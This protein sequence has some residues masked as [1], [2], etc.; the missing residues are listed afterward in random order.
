VRPSIRSSVGLLLVATWSVATPA[1]AARDR[2]VEAR[3][4]LDVHQE[5]DFNSGTTRRGFTLIESGSGER[6]TLRFSPEGEPQLRTGS[7]IVVRGLLVGRELRVGGDPRRPDV[8][9]VAAAEAPAATPRRAV[10]LVVDFSDSA[11]SCSDASIASL[12]FT[13]A[14]SVDGLYQATTNGQVSL[15]GD[16]D[17]NGQPD[18]FRVSIPRSVS[19][20][21]DAYGWAAEAEAAAPAAGVDL[22][23]YQHRIFVL[24]SSTSC[25]WAGLGNVGCGAWCRAWIKTCNVTDIYAHEIGHNLDLAH[26]S[27]DTNNDGAIDCEY[28]DT[29]DFMGYG[30]VGYR[31]T[32][33]PHRHQKAWLPPDKIVEVSTAGTSTWVLS[34]LQ[35]DP[36]TAPYPQVLKIHKADTGDWYYLSYRQRAGYD[37]TLDAAYVDRTSVHRYAGAGYH[38]TL[39]LAALADTSTFSDVPNGVTVRQV[40]H[41]SM[42]ATLQ[43]ATT[44]IAVAPTVT[45]SPARQ[46]AQPGV[47]LAYT[48]TVTNHDPAVC[49]P[50]AFDLSAS[51]PTG[52][53][54]TLSGA[55][56]VLAPGE[57][58]QR[59]LTARSALEATDGDGSIEVA[60]HD[61]SE[62]THGGSGSA[63][64]AV[65]GTAPSAP[66][67]LAAAIRRKTDVE[68]L[69]IAAQDDGSG[70]ASYR[71]LR[72]GSLVATTSS[73]T[74][75]DRDTTSS[76]TY[77]YLVAALDGVGNE[78]GPSNTARVTIGG[79]RGGSKEIC[80]DGLD[81][82]ADGRIDCADSDCAR[83]RNCR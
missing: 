83:S 8:E 15:P 1:A 71:V 29:S 46:S 20:S 38:N 3:G 34:P 76:Q 52:W 21:C 50:S 19:E 44:C 45:L 37:A 10:V 14:T 25:P 72:N 6:W 7:H 12:M 65:D 75:I 77:D 57:Q 42:S 66:T 58:G 41:D 27:T 17:G 36:A 33:G 54:G 11:V 22:A 53:S 81:N 30:G 5:D 74:W 67:S 82:D 32:N 43:I 40:S 59:T 31:M 28:C 9:V 49:E 24:P 70:V 39:L 35:A 26:A 56:L 80:T 79:T 23:L 69:W 78:S 62:S 55:S 2:S 13:G 63:I 51:V 48:A 16:T 4:T 60:A 68:L 47:D 64:Y 18:V 73:T 61:A